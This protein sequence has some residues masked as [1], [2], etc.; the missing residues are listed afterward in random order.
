[1]QKCHSLWKARLIGRDLARSS[2]GA[3]AVVTGWCYVARGLTG[4]PS[5]YDLDSQKRQAVRARTSR[6]VGA[7]RRLHAVRLPHILLRASGRG[8]SADQRG[9]PFLPLD[10]RLTRASI[11]V[12]RLPT[13]FI[14]EIGRI[15]SVQRGASDRPA[16]LCCG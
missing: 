8:A 9:R 10:A 14:S 11:E 7:A 15:P 16:P 1:M 12:G 4:T 3:T 2:A 5:R 6:L 13:M